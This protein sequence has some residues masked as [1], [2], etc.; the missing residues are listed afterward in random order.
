MENKS[1]GSK[2]RLLRERS[3]KSVKEVIEELQKYEIY[4][5]DKTLYSYENDKRTAN[6]DMFLALC[7]IYKCNNIM[8]VFSDA[9]DDVLFTNAEWNIIEKYR[10]LDDDGRKHID[11][12]LNR[13]AYRVN[14]LQDLHSQLENRPAALIDFPIHPDTPERYI[15]YFYS[16]SAG[17]GQV[18]FDD[19]Y[20]DRIVIPDI[21]KYRRV[22]YAVKVTGHSMEP[23]YFDGDNLLVE[24]TC[25]IQVGEIG[26]FNVDGQAYVKKLGDGELISLN[27]GYDNIPLTEGARCMGRVVDRFSIETD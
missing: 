22:A 26:I 17:T 23:L 3:K 10:T 7:K 11:Y 8:E 6:M 1:F 13:E 5:T 2:L 24:P 4:I 16:V 21:P 27:K 19:A 15:Q 25:E 14:Q 20:S 12:E 9:V 18:I